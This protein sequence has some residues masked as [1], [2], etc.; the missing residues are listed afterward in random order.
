VAQSRY[1]QAQER[2]VAV[3][4]YTSWLIGRDDRALRGAVRAG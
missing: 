4:P 2:L 1:Q 3:L